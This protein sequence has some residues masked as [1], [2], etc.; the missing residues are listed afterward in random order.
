MSSDVVVHAESVAKSYR[1][2]ATP[3][4]RLKQLFAVGERKYYREFAALP[5]V[6]FDVKRGETVGIIGRNGSGKSTLLQIVCG[7]LQPPP[8]A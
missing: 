4:D 7:T 1:L 2:Y 8:G 6:S 5:D 3:R